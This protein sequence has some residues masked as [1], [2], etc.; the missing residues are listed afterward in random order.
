M[1]PHAGRSCRAAPCRCRRRALAAGR[2]KDFGISHDRI[3]EFLRIYADRNGENLHS[4]GERGRRSRA[5]AAPV[6]LLRA[7]AVGGPGQQADGRTLEI[8]SNLSANS[9]GFTPIMSEKTYIR[10]PSADVAPARGPFPSCFSVP[11]PSAGPDRRSTEGFWEFTRTY[12][13]I[14]ANLRRTYRRKPSFVG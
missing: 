12:R 6:G 7:V 11:L 4:E 2:R 8:H 14:P 10:G 5:R 3:G 9:C 1:L 13:R